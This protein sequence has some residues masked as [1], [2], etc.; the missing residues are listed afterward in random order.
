MQLTP[1]SQIQKENLIFHQPKEQNIKNSK[2]TY[3][4]LKIE[5]NYQNNKQGLL[6]IK[7]PF[8]FSFGVSEIKDTKCKELSGYSLPICLWENDTNPTTEEHKFHKALTNLT[9]ICFQHLEDSFGPELAN[10]LKSPLYY[11]NIEYTDKK[12]K[13]KKKRDGN[14]APVLSAKF[15]YS[16]KNYKILTLLKT[17]KNKSVDPFD[18]LN[19]YCR[20]KVPLIIEGLY[21]SNNVVSLQIKNHEVYVKEIPQRV[22]L[23]TIDEEGED[24][25]DNLDPV[26]L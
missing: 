12:D 26:E 19:Q 21:L 5:T 1:L 20:V 23:L 17:K 9:D 16:K 18:Y 3:Q 10:D 24:N 8:P 15:I 6:I 22:S 25:E 2:L 4:R 14:S 13:K 11:K 7:S